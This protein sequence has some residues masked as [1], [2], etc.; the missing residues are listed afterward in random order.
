MPL[1]DKEEIQRVQS[2]NIWS[3]GN[4]VLYDM[5]KRTPLHTNEEEI[6]GK[7]WLIGRSYAAALER[8]AK[9]PY[10][11]TDFYK[12]EVAE[13]IKAIGT[14][15]DKRIENLINQPALKREN[16]SE[17]LST[18]RFLTDVFNSISGLDNRSL[19]SKYLHF[20]APNVFYIYDSI[21]YA[22]VTKYKL[23]DVQLKKE[24]KRSFCD[25]TYLDFV[26]KAYPLNLKIFEEHDVWLLPRQLDSLLLKY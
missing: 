9:S 1:I 16:L 20:H 26:S 4:Q 5:C 25:A 3:F 22:G 13:K 12:Y 17:V 2:E 10:K 23:L 7:V 24:L 19:A 8:R 21:A 14:E 18:H 15:L 6:I 11:G